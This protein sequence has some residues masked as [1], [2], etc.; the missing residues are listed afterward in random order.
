MAPGAGFVLFLALTLTLLVLVVL[1]GLR[2][3]R[4]VHLVL[5]ATTLASLGATIFFAERLGTLYDLAA[6]GRIQGVHLFFAK[7]TVVAYLVP[8][9]TGLW[10]LRDGSRRRLHGRIAFVVLALTVVTAV[11]G[12]W[13][14]LAAERLPAA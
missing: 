4:R 11:T 10:T 8:V 7:T 13:M 12:V 1:T 9:A 6:A 3:R 5:V 2:A 14:L